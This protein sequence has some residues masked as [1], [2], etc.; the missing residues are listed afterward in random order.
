VTTDGPRSSL[1]LAGG[2][3][4]GIA[5]ELGL[6]AGLAEQDPQLVEELRAPTTTIV[7]TSAGSVVGA[8]LGSPR[9]MA[10]L[11]APDLEER[12]AAAPDSSIA[13]LIRLVL[14]MGVARLGAHSPEER[15][16][17][18]GRFATRARTIT[19]EEWRSRILDRLPST[20]W[21]AGRLLL[22]AVDVDSGDL[23]VFDRNSG[24]PLLDAVCASCAVPG[25]YPPVRIDGATYMDGGMR[26]IA[27]ADLASP[28]DRVLVLAPLSRSSGMGS[29]SSSE[30]SA[31][32]P[33]RIHTITADDA[34]R[35]AFG[36]N[37]LTASR[38][39]SARA[40]L[41]QGRSIATE[42]RAFWRSERPLTP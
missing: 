35:R 41:E 11:V 6:L 10:E 28:A 33:A 22:A 17:R 14:S 16:R 2:G 24:V 21:P 19:T 25:V 29:L 42:V 26:S 20:D 23:R 4:A 31:L 18:I 40:G 3:S 27:N 9:T 39:D 38:R 12:P 7:G 32:A 1:V 13:D 37:P 30:L 8:S 5:W 34:S 36:R 15:R